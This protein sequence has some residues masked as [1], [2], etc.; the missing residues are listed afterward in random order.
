[1]PGMSGWELARQIKARHLG[2]PVILLTGWQEQAPGDATDRQAVDVVLGKPVRL[3]ELLRA[4]DEA[5]V[6]PA[7]SRRD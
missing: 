2:V 4:L 1:M 5:G 6:R 3:S 7:P